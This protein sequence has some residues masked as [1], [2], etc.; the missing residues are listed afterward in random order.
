MKQQMESKVM[1]SSSKQ[2]ILEAAG[3]IFAENGFRIVTVRE[4][5]RRAGVNVA[6]INYHF[7]DKEG[8]YKEVLSR[9][10]AAAYQRYPLEVNGYEPP[11]EQLKSFIRAFLF[12][13]LGNGRP[14]WFGK[15]VAR[16]FIEPTAALD[17]LIENTIRPT[18]ITL[19]AIVKRLLPEG[20]S[21][22]EVSLSCAS[23]IGQ[24]IYFHN[25]RHVMERLHRQSSYMAEEI[26]GIARHVTE[27]SL[28]ALI[29]FKGAKPGD[30]YGKTGGVN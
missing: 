3:E 17:M 5:C 19:S 27:F 9:W 16:E 28:R 18:Y 13:M 4:I 2:R 21:E 30:A 25:A 29:N 20:A 7:G 26:E 23:I 14:S 22:E 8:L 12:R 11:E 15:L 6:A 10:Q 24:C 1:E